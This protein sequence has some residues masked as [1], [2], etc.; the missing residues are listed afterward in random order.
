[1]DTVFRK[2]SKCDNSSGNCVE[3][4]MN[5]AGAVAVRDS[6]SPTGG[7]LLFTVESWKEFV[8]GVKNDE[9]DVV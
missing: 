6:A 5:H 7:L 8:A 4:A 3:V 2:S 9:F 1:M